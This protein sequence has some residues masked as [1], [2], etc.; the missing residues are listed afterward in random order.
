MREQ[1]KVKSERDAVVNLSEK[2]DKLK[3]EKER[4]TSATK[5]DKST[6]GG[7]DVNMAIKLKTR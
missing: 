3:V 7:F 5:S 1:K 6:T 2:L 4:L